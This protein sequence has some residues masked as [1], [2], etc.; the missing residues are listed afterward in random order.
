[1][2]VLHMER[3]MDMGAFW[4]EL[5]TDDFTKREQ[6]ALELTLTCCLG[7]TQQKLIQHPVEMERTS[8]Q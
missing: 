8:Q 5:F 1:M 2:L 4:Q 6:S 3:D 7:Y